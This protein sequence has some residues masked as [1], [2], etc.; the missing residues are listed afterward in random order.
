MGT[1]LVAKYY[2]IPYT[3]AKS[4]QILSILKI[5]NAKNSYAQVFTQNY[6]PFFKLGPSKREW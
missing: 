2:F 6:F 1:F 4:M 3:R 5:T